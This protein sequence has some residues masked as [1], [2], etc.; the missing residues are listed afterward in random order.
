MASLA[1]GGAGADAGNP[2]W[3]DAVTDVRAWFDQVE[4]VLSPFRADS[5]L[6]RW[7]TGE[8]RLE[9][10]SPLLSEVLVAV[11]PLPGRT[12]GGFHPYDRSGRYDPTGYVKGWAVE[13]GADLLA[14]HGVADACV[15]I[16]GDLQTIGRADAERPWR[17]AV[18]DPNDER[19][20]VAIVSAA[21]PRFA[22]ATSGT[23]H[24]GDHIWPDLGAPAP[25][26]R[27]PLASITVVGPRLGLADAF[28]TAVWA[29]SARRPLDAAWEW[30]PPDYDALAVTIEGRIA[31]T[32]GMHRHR[33]D[34][35]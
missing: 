2:R 8:V 27:H 22:V 23:S 9:D 21:E 5:D 26:H 35:N 1:I 13:R 31:T 19:R 18:V 24:R 16:G 3:Q 33:M 28:A 10:C 20:P 30:L 4:A 34:P 6:N 12:A 7:R 15:G 14:Q 29:L 11:E 25:L 32:P 17:L